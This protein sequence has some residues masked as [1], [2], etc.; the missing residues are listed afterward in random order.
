MPGSHAEWAFRIP[1]TALPAKARHA[2]WKAYAV[3]RVEKAPDAKPDATAFTAGIY[4]NKAKTHV[5]S[6]NPR[7]RDIVGE[8][9]HG[10]RRRERID[11]LRQPL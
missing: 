7:L 3:I 9:G 2:R 6:L 5:A 10:T 4:D 1:G 11:H 8:H